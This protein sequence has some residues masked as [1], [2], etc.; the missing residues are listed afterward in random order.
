MKKISSSAS[1]ETTD[2]ARSS[3]TNIPSQSNETDKYF[4]MFGEDN[5][6]MSVALQKEVRKQLALIARQYLLINKIVRKRDLKKLKDAE[7][8]SLM[9]QHTRWFL[10]MDRPNVFSKH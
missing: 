8:I 4:A 1:V 9:T 7:C 5:R 3:D 2:S 10:G 6:A